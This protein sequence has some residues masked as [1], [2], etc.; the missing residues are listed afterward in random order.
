M[1]EPHQD[2][3]EG[4]VERPVKWGVF[5]P[6]GDLIG[7]SVASTR[8]KSLRQ[9]M[10]SWKDQSDEAWKRFQADGWELACFAPQD[11]M[12]E[13]AARIEAWLESDG[14]NPD[15]EIRALLTDWRRLKAEKKELEE[16]A[17]RVIARSEAA[18]SEALAVLGEVVTVAGG[19]LGMLDHLRDM[20]CMDLT[21]EDDR[22]MMSWMT[23]AHAVLARATA[24]LEK[25]DG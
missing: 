13:A 9:F 25:K 24:V 15:D 19:V 14:L 23:K 1:T 16:H 12:E 17:S 22:N 10:S 4:A 21:E 20:E 3:V 8:E 7:C 5:N 2:D 11:A 18:H 6:D